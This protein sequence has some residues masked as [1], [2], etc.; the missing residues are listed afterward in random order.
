MQ[1]TVQLN[2]K[3]LNNI[4]Y[5]NSIANIENDWENKNLAIFDNINLPIDYNL[6]N[7]IKNLDSSKIPKEVKK[8]KN[9]YLDKLSLFQYFYD[10]KIDQ[11][12]FR[13][14]ILNCNYY[15]LKFIKNL[16][17][18]KIIEI[19]YT[20]RLSTTIFE[21]LHYDIYE[22]NPGCFTFRLFF[23]IDNYPR[24]WAL[25]HTMKE[26]L[27]KYKNQIDFRQIKNKPINE[28]AK[29]LNK[30]ILTDQIEKHFISF[31][32][33]SMWIGNSVRI[34]HQILFGRKMIAYSITCKN[35]SLKN[36]V[37]INDNYITSICSNI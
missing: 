11:T 9:K 26:L 35:S 18:Y 22:D 1:T 3:V 25:S 27:E 30:N 6:L 14:M 10:S 23:N 33:K 28:I 36:Q 32:P 19:N 8:L 16:V 29:Y 2:P 12:E 13:R 31:A 34:P 37:M 7:R 17:Q 24:L 20:W 5:Y 4:I 21:E 15:I